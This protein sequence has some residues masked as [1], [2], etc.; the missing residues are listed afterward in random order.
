MFRL[1]CAK[2]VW[3]RERERER[4]MTFWSE[5]GSHQLSLLLLSPCLPRHCSKVN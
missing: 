4:K 2:S 1:F 3:R 5:E